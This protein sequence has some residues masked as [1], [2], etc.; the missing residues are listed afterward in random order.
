MILHT[1]KCPSCD[2]EVYF[3]KATTI[4]CKCRHRCS[5]WQDHPLLSFHANSLPLADQSTLMM[6]VLHNM[7]NH[8]IHSIGR[9]G[10]SHIERMKASFRDHIQEYVIRKQAEIKVHIGML[11][12]PINFPF[13]FFYRIA[14]RNARA[15]RY[16]GTIF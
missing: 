16:T 2:A 14:I 11:G 13:T 15:S 10:H 1:T 8:L 4:R 6:M 7:S 9:F 5:Y 12:S 3:F